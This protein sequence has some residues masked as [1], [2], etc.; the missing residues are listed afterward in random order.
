MAV[1]VRDI[2]SAMPSRL[3]PDAAAGVDAV[4][5]FDISGEEAGQWYVVIK[6]GTCRIDKGSHSSPNV[7]FAMGSADFVDMMIGKLSGQQAFFSGKLRISGDLML[8]QRLENFFK[9]D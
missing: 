5:Q 4:F 8:A 9:R 6:D 7:T 3:D 2:I 1:S